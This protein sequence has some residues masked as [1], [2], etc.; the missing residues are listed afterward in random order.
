MTRFHCS[1]CSYGG[2]IPEWNAIKAANEM[3]TIALIWC[4]ALIQVCDVIA[5]KLLQTDSSSR[6][7]PRWMRIGKWN[8]QLNSFR[9]RQSLRIVLGDFE[10][11]RGRSTERALKK[12]KNGNLQF[13]TLLWL[14]PPHDGY[15]PI[16][17]E[18]GPL[19]KEMWLLSWPCTWELYKMKNM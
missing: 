14:L 13:W 6:R 15:V 7:I 11:Q 12:E 18:W 16:R 10:W 19:I 8:A 9:L 2:L 5:T 1:W 4:R 3:L 17:L